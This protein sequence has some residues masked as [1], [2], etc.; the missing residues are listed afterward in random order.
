MA[1]LIMYQ[2]RAGEARPC[3]SGA[4]WSFSRE[5]LSGTGG[6][7][8]WPAGQEAL[9]SPVSRTWILKTSSPGLAVLDI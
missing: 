7:R 4:I 3:Q 9:A 5:L 6:L 1:N 2:I 8:A